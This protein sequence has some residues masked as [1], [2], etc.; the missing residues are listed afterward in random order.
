MSEVAENVDTGFMDK[1]IDLNGTDV[2]DIILFNPEED[3]NLPYVNLRTKKRGETYDA[4][5]EDRRYI[6]AKWNYSYYGYTINGFYITEDK[7]DDRLIIVEAKLE[8]VEKTLKWVESGRGYID[9]N[10]TVYKGTLQKICSIYDTTIREKFVDICGQSVPWTELYSMCPSGAMETMFSYFDGPLNICEKGKDIMT[11]AN[12]SFALC[13]DVC[14]AIRVLMNNGYRN[15]ITKFELFHGGIRIYEKGMCRYVKKEYDAFPELPEEAEKKLQRHFNKVIIQRLAESKWNCRHNNIARDICI[16]QKHDG[17]LYQRVYRESVVLNV[18]I[19]KSKIMLF[20]VRR[21][22]ICPGN[23]YLRSLIGAIPIWSEDLTGTIL[24]HGKDIIQNVIKEYDSLVETESDNLYERLDD[25]ISDTYRIPVQISFNPADF[26]VFTSLIMYDAVA[27]KIMKFNP[28]FLSW[29]V[30]TVFYIKDNDVELAI[31][32]EFGETDRAASEL[33][34]I[35]K[36]PKGLLKTVCELEY[37]PNQENLVKLMKFVFGGTKTAND[38]FMRMQKDDFVK[39]A[40]YL[41]NCKHGIRNAE[42]MHVFVTVYGPNNWKNFISWVKENAEVKSIFEVDMYLEYMNRIEVINR[43]DTD[44]AKKAEWKLVGDALQKA[45]E[46]IEPAYM[47]AMD[48]SVYAEMAK[49]F[50]E[51]QKLWSWYNFQKGSYFVTHPEKPSDMIKEGLSLHNCVKTYIE[52]VAD[53]ETMIFF[54]RKTDKPFKPFFTV[55]VFANEIRQCLGDSNCSIYDEDESLKDFL[56]DFCE[57]K[58]IE[59]FDGAEPLA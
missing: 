30:G 20:E 18:P 58:K 5:A 27:E 33:H 42:I 44:A 29:L 56:Q 55:E 3:V 54:I 50:T 9:K 43:V 22:E 57:E 14:L 38:Y 51:R 37:I 40:E 52:E 32:N 28:L 47:V 41:G 49:K 17:K 16:L 45:Y 26:V 39:L 35:M 7:A 46:S 21:I 24:E 36:V 25:Y 34:K 11:E 31:K 6:V 13:V 59:Y 53:G 23:L 8:W 10:G 19:E 48:S 15:T 1:K 4:V 12:I 2:S